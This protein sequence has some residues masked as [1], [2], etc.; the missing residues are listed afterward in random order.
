MTV[1][2]AGA[3]AYGA[4]A[5]HEVATYNNP[6]DVIEYGKGVVKVSGN[7]DGCK[8]PASGSDE[9]LGVAIYDQSSSD[10]QYAAKSAVGIGK[11]GAFWVTV[12]EAVTPDDTVYVRYA[13]KMQVQTIVLDADLVTSNVFEGDVNGSAVS[14]TFSVDHLT[15]MG[16]MATAIDAIDGVDSAVV[17]GAGNRTITVTAS[18]VDA[19]VTLENFLITLGASQA[20]ITITET[21][22]SVPSSKIGYFRNDADSSTAMACTGC[23]FRS[24]ASANGV[25][26][27]DVNLP[28]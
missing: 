22:A 21:I 25:A 28:Q 15:T 2:V 16:L 8:L 4:D 10:G 9:L 18:S 17:G 3:Y 20:N 6:T 24:S 27:L 11:R 12:D 14:V 19:D 5:Q 7:D 23:K 26:I 13:G 1:A